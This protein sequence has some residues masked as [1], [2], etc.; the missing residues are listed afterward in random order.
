M[1]L[2]NIN[3]KSSNN[4][5]LFYHKKNIIQSNINRIGESM[6]QFLELYSEHKEDITSYLQNT[7]KNNTTIEEDKLIRYKRNFKHFPSMNVLYITD[8]DYK[9]ITPTIYRT[10]EVSMD[11]GTSKEYLVSKLKEENDE[12]AISEPYLSSITGTMSVTVKQ[13]EGDE[14]V[15]ID[16][17]LSQLL[18]QLGLIELHHTFDNFTK[19]FYQ[20]IGFSLMFFALLAIVYAFYTFFSHLGHGAVGHEADGISLNALFKPII[21]ITLGLAIFD[22][23]KNI[24]QH[25]VYYKRYGKDHEEGMVLRKFTIAILIALSIE[26]LMV[27]FKITLHG[28]QDMIYGLYL[29]GGVGIIMVSLGLYN[30]LSKSSPH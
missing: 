16:Y 21:S 26:A 15:F 19:L 28:Y 5:L 22:L 17:K 4:Y 2:I 29:I 12:F 13:K 20:I 14:Y 8:K 1:T 7:L 24:L 6:K 25:E 23:A 10:K 3:A 9:Q 30:Y 11:M 27:I 18:A